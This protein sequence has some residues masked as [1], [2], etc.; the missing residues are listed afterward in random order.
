MQC[1]SEKNAPTLASY[2]FDMHALILIIFS[3]QHQHTFRNDTHIQLSLSLHFYLLYLLL[4]SC[5]GNDAR[6]RNLLGRV[7]VA[8]KRAG[9]AGWLALFS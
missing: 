1:V 3:Q 5:D 4:N 2:S 9:C 7:L 8:L 6:Q